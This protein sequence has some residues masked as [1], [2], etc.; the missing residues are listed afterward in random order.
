LIQIVKI[1]NEIERTNGH[2]SLRQIKVNQ[3]ERE[4]RHELIRFTT[5]AINGRMIECHHM[6][7]NDAIGTVND[8]KQR[9]YEH[10]DHACS[11]SDS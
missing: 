6:H 2:T 1:E 4:N 8:A 11:S 7:T 3:R 9:S 5:F 10:S